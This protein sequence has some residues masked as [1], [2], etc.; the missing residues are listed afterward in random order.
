MGKKRKRADPMD[1]MDDGMAANTDVVTLPDTQ[2]EAAQQK[3]E[4]KAAKRVAKKEAKAA[5][6]NGGSGD[7]EEEVPF[8]Y[9]SA[10]SI[11]N[12][13]R[14]GGKETAKERKKKER[15]MNPYAKAMDAP[16]GLPRKQKEKAGKS[17]TYKY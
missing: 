2:S 10:P 16:K 9:A 17:M 7:G 13:P 1:T 14:E 6:T 12:P 15:Q 11:L 5:A 8:D 4:R 3:R